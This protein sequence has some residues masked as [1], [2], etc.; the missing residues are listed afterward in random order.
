MHILSNFL[1]HMLDKYMRTVLKKSFY[2]RRV[3][4]TLED[5]EEEEE[6]DLGLNVAV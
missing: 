3:G 6:I 2:T 1:E 5:S 4:F